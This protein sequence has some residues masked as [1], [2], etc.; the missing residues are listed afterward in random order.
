MWWKPSQALGEASSHTGRPQMNWRVKHRTADVMKVF[1]LFTCCV[2]VKIHWQY[3]SAQIR[4]FFY[5]PSKWWVMWLNCK[6]NW[7]QINLNLYPKPGRNVVWI[8]HWKKS[9]VSLVKVVTDGDL[10]ALNHQ[11]YSLWCV[12]RSSCGNR[13][14]CCHRGEFD[15]LYSQR[16]SFGEISK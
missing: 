6:W 5:F 16:Q 13:A 11:K 12:F 2:W 4:K 14:G 7:S 15:Q 9:S 1:T 3:T 8:T 10:S